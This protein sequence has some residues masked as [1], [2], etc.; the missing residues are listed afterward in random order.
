[1]SPLYLDTHVVIWLY[2]GRRDLFPPA[3]AGRLDRHDLLISPMV[4][5]ELEY[6]YECGKVREDSP[7]VLD[8]LHREIGLTLCDLPFARVGEAARPLRWTRDPFD[9]LITAHAA[10]R[11]APLL[12]RDAGLRER[13][14]QA[15]WDG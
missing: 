6:L 4:A 3:A 13:Y 12:T 2:A 7:P 5:L 10:A 15:V 11:R 1:M 9:R 14:P 8:A